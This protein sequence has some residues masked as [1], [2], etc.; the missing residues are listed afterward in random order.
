MEA[1]FGVGI[2]NFGGQD[3]LT[4]NLQSTATDTNTEVKTKTVTNTAT[5]PLIVPAMSLIE[6]SHSFIQFNVPVQYK[7]NVTVDGQLAPNLEGLTQISQVLSDADRTFDFSG[8]VTD[9]NLIDSEISTKQKVLTAADCG[10]SKEF[11]VKSETGN[12]F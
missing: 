7:G 8:F 4:L 12:H 6:V 2:A 3:T 5:E 1:K 10:A 9:S 11:T